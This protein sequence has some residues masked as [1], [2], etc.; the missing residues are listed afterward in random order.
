MIEAI[1]LKKY[2]N[3]SIQF[4]AQHSYIFPNLCKLLNLCIHFKLLMSLNTVFKP[5]NVQ[6]LD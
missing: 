3:S 2:Y 5:N 6:Y 1:L 4:S